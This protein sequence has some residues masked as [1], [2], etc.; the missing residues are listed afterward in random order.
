M[1]LGVTIIAEVKTE[2]PFGYKAEQS[3]E[4]LFA[5]ASSVGDIVSIHTDL[6]WCGSFERLERARSMTDK[7]IL[8]KGI[9]ASDA[10]IERALAC[11][12]DWVL[13]VGRVP[14][15]AVEKCF[16]EPNTLEELRALPAG[17]RA[18]WNSRDLQTGGLKDETFKQ[19]REIFP[20]WLCQ[21]SNIKS[22]ADIGPGADA[23]LV[24]THLAAFADS[25]V[26]I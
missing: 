13:V 20:G 7:P 6:R 22:I 24:G 8:A 26:T 10:E 23:V 2:S 4:E 14:H 5:I 11:G 21:A 19:A 3:W 15:V 16:I 9:H 1:H 17:L 12:A 25:L 18:V